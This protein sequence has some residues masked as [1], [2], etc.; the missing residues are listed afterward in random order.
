MG[1][2]SYLPGISR[3]KP[4]TTLSILFRFRNE[5]R[6]V[7]ADLHSALRSHLVSQLDQLRRRGEAGSGDGEKCGRGRG[8]GGTTIFR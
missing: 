6:L 3:P 2:S 8:G 7:R 1:T 5:L 4:V